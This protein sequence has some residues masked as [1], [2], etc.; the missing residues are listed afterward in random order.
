MI[1]REYYPT[2]CFDGDL[3]SLGIQS[4]TGPENGFMKP[5]YLAFRFGDCTPESSSDKVIWISRAV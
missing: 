4:L 3:P 1:L 2:W 5:K